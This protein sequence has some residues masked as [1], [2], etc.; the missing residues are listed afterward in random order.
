MILIFMGLPGSGKGTQAQKMAS[1][2]GLTHISTG[3][4]VRH[5]IAK[6]TDLGQEI[7]AVVEAGGFPSDDIILLLVKKTLNPDQ[8]I[9]FDGFPR[10][11]YQADEFDKLLDQL[12]LF[13]T[14]V[15]K[16]DIKDEIV[17]ERLSSRFSCAQCGHIYN[18]SSS[19]LKTDG[20]CNFCQGTEFVTRKDDSEESILKRLKIYHDITEPIEKYYQSMGLLITVD[21]DQPHEDVSQQLDVLLKLETSVQ[22]QQQSI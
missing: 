1:K 10:T 16:F 12:G 18:R 7:K 17:V 20:T 5:E 14:A 8:N 3:D 4:L 11:K 2:Y 21:A 9:I 13:L 15:I 6:A 22:G 19:I